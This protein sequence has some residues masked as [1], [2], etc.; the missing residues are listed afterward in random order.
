MNPDYISNSSLKRFFNITAEVSGASEY[1]TE[2]DNEITTN[3]LRYYTEHVKLRG[4]AKL[5]LVDCGSG[6]AMKML[7]DCGF[8]PVGIS[9]NKDDVDAC[10]KR[11]YEAYKMH[12]AFLEFEDSSFDCVWARHTLSDSFMP[13]YTLHEFK[14]VL[15]PGGRL[16][17]EVTSNE[18]KQETKKKNNFTKNTWLDLL[19]NAGFT[20]K[21][22]LVFNLKYEK[23]ENEYWGFDCALL[24]KEKSLSPGSTKPLYLALSSGENFGWGVCSKYLKQEVSKLRPDTI[25]WDYK[26]DTDGMKPVEGKLFHALLDLE[27]ESITKL[28]G[29]EN[30]GYTFFENELNDKSV[31]NAKKYD[32]VLGGSTW[33]KDKMAEKGISNID[34][35]IQGVD[36]EVFYPIEEKK[37][38][39]LFVIFSGG[40]FELRKGQDLVLKAIQI[41]QQKYPDIILIN[42]WYNMWPN[43]MKLMKNSKYIDFEY[44]GKGWVE[45]MTNIYTRNGIDPNRV[46][47]YEL[48]PNKE[49]RGF[50][51]ETDIG[52]FP[53]RCEGGTNLVLM[54][55]MACAKPVIASYN[56]GHTDVL[57]EDNS[58]MLTDMKPYKLYDNSNNLWADWADPSLDEI[59]AK[60]E[61]AYNNRDEIRRLGKRAGEDMKKLTWTESARSLLKTMNA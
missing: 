21:E 13:Y 29:D 43:S 28:R 35:L 8:E 33:C 19:G 57:T 11:G 9:L 1:K 10:K 60:I 52:L 6:D 41:L 7:D 30:Y 37:D 25:L 15:K 44:K 14:R 26:Q 46:L 3:V 40:K 39:D 24:R 51:G 32:K 5:L 2:S 47:T 49:L 27:F 23:H 58:L 56:T 48:I 36:P 59:I 31:E 17:V 22:N 38:E 50:Y 18:S 16:Y 61:Y 42:A 34:V 45:I 53:N 54:E 4:G 55:Y 20:P 12:Q